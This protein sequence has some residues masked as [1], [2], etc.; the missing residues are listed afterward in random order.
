MAF[1]ISYGQL[2]ELIDEFKADTSSFKEISPVILCNRPAFV[3]LLR[4]N[5]GLSQPKFEEVT[6]LTNSVKYEKE[7]IKTMKE[8]TAANILA[9][10]S[11]DFEPE[12]VRRFFNKFNEESDGWFKANKTDEKAVRARQKGAH[13]SM[14]LRLTTQEDDLLK[15]L[16]KNGF[17]PEANKSLG[18]KIIA[19]IVLPNCVIE[20]KRLVTTNRRQQ[21]KKTREL[22][23]EGY[24]I[25][26]LYPTLKLY[27]LIEV[28]LP[29]V[30]TDFEELQGPFDKVFT[31]SEDLL[32][33]LGPGQKA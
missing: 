28:K 19:D 9:K 2:N 1:K 11:L 17:K 7:K 26:F 8:K 25:K 22:A 16:S 30:S 14:K 15:K 29:L 4:L 24:K 10:V 5:M 13:A 23:Y 6:G 32:I 12:R 33:F 20:C 27:A 21:T 3:L 18:N 31:N